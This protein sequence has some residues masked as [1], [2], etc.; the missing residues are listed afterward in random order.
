MCRN[1]IKP[2][3]PYP[4]KLQ[5]KEKLQIDKRAKDVELNLELNLEMNLEMNL[6]INLEISLE[7]S[8]EINLKMHEHE[9]YG[10][11]YNHSKSSI[12]TWVG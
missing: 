3:L 1:L 11:H 7:M 8:S 4:R 10:E 6:E 5:I 2:N 9:M 12:V